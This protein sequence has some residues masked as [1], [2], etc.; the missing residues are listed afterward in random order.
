VEL[1]SR[2]QGLANRTAPSPVRPA[3]AGRGPDMAMR[4]YHKGLAAAPYSD[5]VEDGDTLY[6]AG[7]I[8]QDDPAWAGRQGTIE[9]ET[10]AAMARIGAILAGAGFSFADVVRVGIFMTDL[11]EFAR[12]NSVYAAYFPAEAQPARTCVGVRELLF[13]ARIEIE[14]I[15]R[16]RLCA[17]A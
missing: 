9:A 15:A 6:V 4:A 5:A 7:Q 12:M 17:H 16:R 14:C 8:A 11:A 13:G 3:A 1:P 2:M 10:A